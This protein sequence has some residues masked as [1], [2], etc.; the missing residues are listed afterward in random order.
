M[1][2]NVFVVD[3]GP[4]SLTVLPYPFKPIQTS[5]SQWKAIPGI[6]SKRAT[7]IKAT[8]SMQS[9]SD[10]ARALDMELPSWVTRAMKFDSQ[11]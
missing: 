7:R 5:L 3:H 8:E 2:R 1:P 4:R 9:I 6:G 10:V 11:K